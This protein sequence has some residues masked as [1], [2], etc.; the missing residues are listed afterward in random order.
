MLSSAPLGWES[1]GLFC[2]AVVFLD[3]F[4]VQG[5]APERLDA[6]A[7]GQGARNGR[8]IG[9]SELD[10]RPPDHVAVPAGLTAGGGIDDHLDFAVFD[11][12]QDVGADTGGNLGDGLAG[13]AV[14]G[15][16]ISR[17]GSGEDSETH[18]VELGRH[19]QNRRLVAIVDADENRAFGGQVLAGPQLGLGVSR[20]EFGVDPRTLGLYCYYCYTMQFTRDYPRLIGRKTAET[21]TETGGCR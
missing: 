2:A 5:L 19:G 12:V 21:T 16:K 7:H 14:G 8:G 17:S 13:D 1:T 3:G 11:G 20:S 15:Q 10:G 18:V 6:A 4:D 9:Q